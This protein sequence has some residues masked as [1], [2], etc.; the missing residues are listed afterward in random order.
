MRLCHALIV[1]LPVLPFV[2]PADDGVP[3]AK[4]AVAALWPDAQAVS[5]IE[6]LPCDGPISADPPQNV[7][8][9]VTQVRLRCTPADGS[10]GW[11]RFLSLKV[12]APD[13]VAVLTRGLAQGQPV[14]PDL[15]RFEPRDRFLSPANAIRNAD[16]LA[17]QTARRELASGTVLT[18]DL[19]VP[20][21]AIARGQSVTLLSSGGGMQVRAPGEAMADAVLG[22]RV[23]VRNSASQR[24]VE[25]IARAGGVV[26]VSL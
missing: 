8:M 9:G 23:R 11:S 15:V 12:S 19:L 13:Q 10:A 21:K 2:A 14:T 7:R 16:A 17:A 18:T 6:H 26:E 22:G 1:L 24:V 25:G 3:A 4:R 20:P 5:A